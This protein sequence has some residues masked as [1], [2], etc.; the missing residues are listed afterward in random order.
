M[1]T[2]SMFRSPAD[3]ARKDLAGKPALLSQF[4]TLWNTF[5]NG[6]TQQSILGNP[7]TASNSS[8]STNYFN[9][10]VTDVP[11]NAVVQNISWNAMP[12][13]ISYYNSADWG[14]LLT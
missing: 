14:S 7:W 11:T 2:L 1:P 8:N 5:V 9:P 12:G 3:Q 13:R 6:F 10:L 4:E